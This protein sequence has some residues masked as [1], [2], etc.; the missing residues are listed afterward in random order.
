MNSEFCMHA[1]SWVT[2]GYSRFC[3]ENNF[4]EF[5]FDLF[6]QAYYYSRVQLLYK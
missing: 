5:F 4:L 2:A 1:W 6:L 3:A